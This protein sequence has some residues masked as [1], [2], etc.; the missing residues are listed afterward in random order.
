MEPDPV[1]ETNCHHRGL[2]FRRQNG[3]LALMEDNGDTIEVGEISDFDNIYEQL[4]DGEASIVEIIRKPF[5]G[6]IL[7]DVALMSFCKDYGQT[8]CTAEEAITEALKE[9]PRGLKM[10]LYNDPDLTEENNEQA[11]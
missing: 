1:G 11:E 8:P 2:I 10:A 4:K 6:R 7:R 9:D 5:G 3:E